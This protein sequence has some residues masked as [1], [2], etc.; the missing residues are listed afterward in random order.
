MCLK[1]LYKWILHHPQVVQ[2]TKAND[3]LKLS[4]D[5]QAGPQLV[6]KLLYQV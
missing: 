3:C 6:P 4:I 2:S 1:A 5:G